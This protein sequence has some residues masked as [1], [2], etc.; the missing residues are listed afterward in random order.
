MHVSKTVRTSPPWFRSVFLHNVNFVSG[1]IILFAVSLQ[2][3]ATQSTHVTPLIPDVTGD[4]MVAGLQFQGPCERRSLHEGQV[5]VHTALHE[6]S[7]LADVILRDG[8]VE[9]HHVQRTGTTQVWT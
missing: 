7:D 5:D 3:A 8:S 4:V 1:I 9:L 6:L 2:A